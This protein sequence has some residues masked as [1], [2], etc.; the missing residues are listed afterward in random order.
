M[1]LLDYLSTPDQR[2]FES[3]GA[4]LGGLPSFLMSAP[5]KS[6]SEQRIYQGVLLFLV[7]CEVQII[8]A[9]ISIGDAGQVRAGG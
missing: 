4:L 5:L 7:F 3:T 9:F 8:L 1:W 6:Y 2:L